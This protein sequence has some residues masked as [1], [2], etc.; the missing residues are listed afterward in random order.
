MCAC[1]LEKR[2]ALLGTPGRRAHKLPIHEPIETGLIAFIF[3][4]HPERRLQPTLNQSNETHKV[5]TL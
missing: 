3:H 5:S 4:L 2:Y 1:A